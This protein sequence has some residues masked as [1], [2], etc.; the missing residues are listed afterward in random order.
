MNRYLDSS[1]LDLDPVLDEVA[2]PLHRRAAVLKY[3]AVVQSEVYRALQSQSR[4]FVRHT[5]APFNMSDDQVCRT[6]VET[7]TVASVDDNSVNA[8]DLSIVNPQQ[9]KEH[10]EAAEDAPSAHPSSQLLSW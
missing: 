10:A 3:R 9:V 1:L 4:R 2:L 6:Q 8:A 5:L 7:I